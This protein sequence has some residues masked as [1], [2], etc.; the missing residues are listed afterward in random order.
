MHKSVV[1]QHGTRTLTDRFEITACVFYSPLVLPAYLTACS[2]EE[3]TWTETS[4]A[5][6]A[7][8][9]QHTPVWG[10]I[11]WRTS[12]L[13]VCSK[14]RQRLWT[15]GLE[16]VGLDDKEVSLLLCDGTCLSG[17]QDW[18]G[19]LSCQQLPFTLVAANPAFWGFS[20]CSFFCL[21]LYV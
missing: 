12:L 10:I 3:D 2:Y 9:C 15:S 18:F 16:F 17:A 21:L 6:R 14:L 4:A 11:P 8:C 7:Q 1:V 19:A 20:S 13:S 5:G